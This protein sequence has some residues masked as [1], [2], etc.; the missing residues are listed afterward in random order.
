MRAWIVY[1]LALLLVS[2]L[3]DEPVTTASQQVLK[4]AQEQAH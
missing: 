3:D 2:A 1:V 4:Q